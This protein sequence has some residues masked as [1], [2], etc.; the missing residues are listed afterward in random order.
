[1][2][3]FTYNEKRYSPFLSFLSL[4]FLPALFITLYHMILR[5]I[6]GQMTSGLLFSGRGKRALGMYLLLGGQARA[7]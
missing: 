6:R 2:F 5:H 7:C 3:I 4:L 1:M